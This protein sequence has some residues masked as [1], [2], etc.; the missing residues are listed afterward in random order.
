MWAYIHANDVP[1][2]PLHDQNYP[3]IGCTHCTRPGDAGRGPARRPL[4]GPGK[5]RVRPAP[6][7]GEVAPERVTAATAR[8]IAPHGGELVDLLARGERA[9]RSGLARGG[10]WRASTLSARQAADLELLAIGGFSPLRGFQGSDDW[11]RVVDEMR[12]ARRAPLEHPGHARER[13]RGR[14]RRRA[15]A[16]RPRRQA[17]RRAGGRGDVRARRRA[18]GRAGVPHEGRQAPRRRRAARRGRALPRRTGAG[19]WTFPSIPDAFQPLPAAARRSR[20]RRS[21]SAAGRRGRLPDP[22]PDP[23]RARVH[24][25]GGAR[26]RRRPLH[27]PAG[28]RDEVGRHPRRRADALLRGADRELLPRRTA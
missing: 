25:Q 8:V 22:Q 15:G 6:R 10:R 9:R 28:R 18:R 24:H 14:G 26:G 20:A 13:R 21:Q 3:S 2:N 16:A 17:A 5:D 12:L 11:K 7:R 23:P 4:G 1:Y 19:S 27:P